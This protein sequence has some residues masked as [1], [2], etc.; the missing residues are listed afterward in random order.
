MSEMKKRGFQVLSDDDMEE[1]DGIKRKRIIKITIVVVII[2]TLLIIGVLAWLKF[3]TYKSYAVKDEIKTETITESDFFDYEGK[4]LKVSKNG[5]IYTDMDGEL[6]WNQSY[7]MN[8]P[9]VDICEEYAV[10]GSKKGNEIYIFDTNGSIGHIE[11]SGQIRAVEVARQGT[12]AVMTQR[13]NS[14]YVNLYD[15]EGTKLVQGEMHLENSGYPIAMSLSNDGIKLMISLV[16]VSAGQAKTVMNFYNF[17]TVG[18]N[19]IDNL[20]ASYKYEDAIIP[21]VQFI[22]DTRAVA[23]ATDGIL[24]YKGSQKPKEVKKVKTTSEIRSVFFCK[25]FVGITYNTDDKDEKKSYHEIAIYDLKGKEIMKERYEQ[26][27]DHVD[28]LGE[29][30]V[31]LTRGENC[32]IY[33]L[34]GTLK[35]KGAMEQPILKMEQTKKGNE[36]MVLFAD[37]IQRIKLK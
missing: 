32:R 31:V 9:I 13:K 11:T 30:E 2:L 33:S 23:Y 5:A 19:E 15:K 4:L 3:K 37:K 36:Y 29:D 21:R 25:K 20:V 28:I 18:Q 6:M 26:D 14:Y 35:F 24:F 16:D 8:A 1:D 17:G 7:E 12:V 34:D 27:Y 10:V 22:D